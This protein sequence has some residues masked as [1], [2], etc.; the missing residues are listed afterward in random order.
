MNKQTIKQTNNA[1]LDDR[2]VDPF[3]QR[4]LSAFGANDS[5]FSQGQHTWMGNVESNTDRLYRHSVHPNSNPNSNPINNSTNNLKLHMSSDGISNPNT[6]A[7][8]FCLTERRLVADLGLLG[9]PLPPRL[10]P[11]AL[12]SLLLLFFL[13]SAFGGDSARC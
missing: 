12:L 4:N 9:L 8:S 13:L 11:A 7:V 2:W 5:L 10:K 3:A 1:C 6:N